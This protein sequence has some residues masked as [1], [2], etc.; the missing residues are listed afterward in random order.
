[1]WFQ[2]DWDNG[3]LNDTTRRC[4]QPGE[5]SNPS[6]CQPLNSYVC[7]PNADCHHGSTTGQC[8]DCDLDFGTLT[9][10]EMWFIADFVY[11]AQPDA[12]SCTWPLPGGIGI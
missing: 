1:M 12:E 10:D 11:Q 9:E 3:V 6:G 8:L 2:C 4:V 7:V 5:P